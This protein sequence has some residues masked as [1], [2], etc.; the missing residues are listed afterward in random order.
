[1]ALLGITWFIRYP[2]RVSAAGKLMA[3]NP[4][5]DLVVRTDGRLQ[6]L[7]YADNDSVQ[8]GSLIAVMQT[9][10]DYQAILA[11]QKIT[12]SLQFDLALGNTEAVAAKYLWLQALTATLNAGELQSDLQQMMS[13]SQTFIQYLQGGYYLRKKE[14]LAKDLVHLADQRR[15]LQQQRTLTEQDIA[16]SA[17][18]FAVSDRLASQQVIAPVE[19][20]NE[21]SKWVN[22]QLQGPQL[23]AALIT[24]QLQQHEKRKEIAQLENDIALQKEFFIQALQEWNSRLAAWKQQYMVVA[25]GSGRLVLDGFLKQGATMQRGEKLGSVVPA[26]A[27]YFVAVNLPQHNFGKLQSG[28]QAILRFSAFPF[29]EFGAVDARLA[30]MKALPTDSGYLGEIVL[31]NGLV[32]NKGLTLSY[33]HG[34]TVHAYIITDQ[35]RLLE[36]LLEGITRAVKR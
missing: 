35:R 26:N 9:T 28:Q 12:D 25:P 11:L 22:K 1:V 14:M 19:F 27:G 21:K 20:R 30:Y 6:H 8:Q 13:T 15:V 32:T 7:F 34:L 3:T 23:E 31:P 16:L 2:D 33:R 10:A 5:Q 24:N 4:P 29:E 36:R 17:D 18:N